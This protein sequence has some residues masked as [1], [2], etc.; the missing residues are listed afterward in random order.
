M[1]LTVIVSIICVQSILSFNIIQS[2]Y[3]TGRVSLRLSCESK[4]NDEVVKQFEKAVVDTPLTHIKRNK[5]AVSV[6]MIRLN[7]QD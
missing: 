5:F 6:N 7:K 1:I 4:P 2:K 3:I